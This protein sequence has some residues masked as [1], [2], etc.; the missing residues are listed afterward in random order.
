MTTFGLQYFEARGA[1]TAAAVRALGCGAARVQLWTGEDVAGGE[2]PLVSREKAEEIIGE[3]VDAGMVPYTMLRRAKQVKHVPPGIPIEYGNEP[4]DPKY[5]F[6]PLSFYLDEIPAFV[7]A[8]ADR[9]PLF[10]AP[11]AN[12]RV[13]WPW[14]APAGLTYLQQIPWRALPNWVGCSHHWYPNDARPHESHIRTYCGLGKR[15]SRDADIDQLRC[16]VG[17]RPLAMSESGWWDSP[18]RSEEEVA[19]WYAQEREIWI[20]NGYEYAIAYQIDSEPPPADPVQWGPQHGYGARRVGSIDDW[21]P[22]TR[23]W[24]GGEQ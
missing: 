16:L 18:Y 12:L 1:E 23:A 7:R 2:H 6:T 22:W 9:N 13:T 3:V 10:L 20:R 11:V 4:E 14:E 19:A 21:K 15:Q 5:G 24:F 17:D 8:C